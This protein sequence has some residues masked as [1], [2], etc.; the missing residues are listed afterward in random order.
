MLSFGSRPL[1]RVVTCGLLFLSG[2]AWAAQPARAAD[3]AIQISA[4]DAVQTGVQLERQRKWRDAI[5]HYKSALQTWPQDEHLTYGLRRAQF[6]F[7][8]DRRYTDRS[9]LT[10]IKSMPRDAALTQFDEVLSQ[11]H[12]HFVDP[13][14]TT[15]IVAHGTESLW[16]ALANERFL[17][18]NLFGADASRV[19]QF[20]QLLREKYWNKPVSNRDGARQMIGEICDIGYRQLGLDGGAVVQEYIYGACNCLDDYSNVLTPGR[21][22][23]LYGNIEGEFVGIGIVMEGELGK[24]MNLVQVLPQSPASESGLRAGDVLTAIEGQDCRF[25]TTDEAAGL[26]TGPSG[27][28]VRLEVVSPNGRREVSVT[29]REVHVKSIP[30]AR[31]VDSEHGI[32]YLQMTG[33]QKSTAQELD[34]ALVQLRKQGMK[35]LIWDLRSNPGGLLT[36]AVEVLDRF[37]GN[38]VLVETRGRTYD[39]NYTYSAHAPGTWDLPIVLL[40]DGNSASASEIVAGAIRDHQRGLIVGRKSFG[41]WSV[42]S[43]YDLR[44]GGG[45]RLTTAKF[46]SPKGDT[47]GK[48]GVKPDLAI[49][50]VAKSQRHLG[51]VDPQN[52]SDVRAAIEAIRGGRVTAAR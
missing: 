10:A 8:I 41:K 30:I 50:A 45:V 47:L 32:A 3:A 23:D 43:I 49:E 18:Q 13:I 31:I 15:S 5:D 29:R 1:Q 11:I 39:Q 24:G 35:S 16:L 22:Q 26:M 48:I 42:Q 40:I 2:F 6:Q 28:K 34:E 52:D 27:S 4:S 20:R 44:G 46:Y 25:M 19:Q 17:D 51:E 14:D 9:F 36:S 12:A 33:F 21:L 37:I 7:A 38:G